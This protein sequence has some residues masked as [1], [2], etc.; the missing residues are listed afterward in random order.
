MRYEAMNVV[1]LNR[2][3]KEVEEQQAS[4]ADL[5]PSCSE[6]RCRYSLRSSKSRQLKSRK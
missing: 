2:L 4:I 3:Q 5:N 6:K 1:F